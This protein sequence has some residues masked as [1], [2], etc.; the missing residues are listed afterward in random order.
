MS[1][2]LGYANQ[3]E[4]ATLSGGNWNASYPQSNIATKY[5]YQ[6]A[7]TANALAVSTKITMDLQSIQDV[8]VVAICKHN[9]TPDV[10]TVQI[11]ASSSSGFSPLLYDSGAMTVYT[12]DD[13]CAAFA[14]VAARYW[15]I[16]I[17]DTSN[18]DGY[19]EIGRV[20][21]GPGFSADRNAS[22]GYS[23]G[24]ESASS[25]VQ[26]LGGAEYPEI[27]PNRRVY[28]FAWDYLT[29]AEKSRLL[30]IKQT[31]D[32][33]GEVFF[34]FDDTSTSNAGNDRFLGRMRTLSQIEAPSLNINQAQMEIA[35]LI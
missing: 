32:I 11:E 22:W 8:A 17:V 4:S 30:R 13:F 5:L 35:E 14:S 24:Y 23:C 12:G 34:I 18:W 27:R 19:V 9:M 7:R 33:T 20:F 25:V 26:A 15:R 6:R 29:D 31:Q 28:Q 3:I 16:S 10:A 21:I 1:V 2:V